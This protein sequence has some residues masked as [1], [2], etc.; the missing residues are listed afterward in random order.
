MSLEASK[1]QAPPPPK[2]QT[3]GEQALGK[4]KMSQIREKTRGEEG[5][6]KKDIVAAVKEQKVLQTNA[7]T[8]LE[9]RFKP[10][11]LRVEQS[12]KERGITIPSTFSSIDHDHEDLTS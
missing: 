12:A 4:E 8:L 3:L 6:L 9:E 2:L 1:E 7:D 11:A 10:L 5:A